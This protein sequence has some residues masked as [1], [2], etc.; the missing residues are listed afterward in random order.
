MSCYPAI[1]E[2][3]FP[4][5]CE[6]ET[7][8]RQILPGN[9]WPYARARQFVHALGLKSSREFRNWAA[10]N[11]AAGLP[12]PGEMPSNPQQVYFEEWRGFSDWLGTNRVANFNRSFLP[13]DRARSFVALLGLET[14]RDWRAY[15][16]GKLPGLGRRPENI[17]SNPNLVYRHSGWCGVKHWLGTGGP[18]LP[19][20]SRMRSFEEARSFARSL[21]LSNQIAWQQYVAGTIPDLPPRPADMPSNP[22]ACYKGKGWMGYGDF[23]GTGHIANHRK[24]MRP[25]AEARM[26]AR[27]L[28]LRTYSEWRAW[29]RTPARPVDIPANPEKTYWA[30]WRGWRDW[31]RAQK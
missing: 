31:L 4:K 30:V 9:F 6:E 13:Y 15:C 11:F 18:G 14:D 5:A 27:A 8:G 28:G 19:G 1:E 21:G 7:A 29:A 23:L 3:D 24:V 16:A 17:P 20:T 25:F 10:G 12:R 2:I 26:L 22:N